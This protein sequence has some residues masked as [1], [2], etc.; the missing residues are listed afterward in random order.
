MSRLKEIG[1]HIS[2]TERRAMA[3]ERDAKD[4]YIAA[5]LSDRVG[6]KFPARINGVTSF[7]LFVTLDETGADGLVPVR[8]GPITANL[9]RR[10]HHPAAQK[11]AIKTSAAADDRRY[12]DT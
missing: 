9:I 7:G 11:R 6:A 8:Q 5:Y 4:R 12:A 3:A 10:N 2:D 1:E